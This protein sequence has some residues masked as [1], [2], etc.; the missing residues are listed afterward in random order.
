MHGDADKG[1]TK[2][3]GGSI[4]FMVDYDPPP[5]PFLQHFDLTI[6]H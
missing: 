2:D 6:N 5:S 4:E 1:H 3:A